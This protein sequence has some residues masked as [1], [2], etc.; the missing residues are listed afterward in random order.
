MDYKNFND[1]RNF[2]ADT[3][4]IISDCR[5]KQPKNKNNEVIIFGLQIAVTFYC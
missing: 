1:F 5:V 3:F 4:G 2:I